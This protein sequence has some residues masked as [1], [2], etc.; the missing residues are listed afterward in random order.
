MSRHTLT[1]RKVVLSRIIITA[2]TLLETLNTNIVYSTEKIYLEVKIH[3]RVFFNKQV[4]NATSS[5]AVKQDLYPDYIF[6]HVVRLQPKSWVGSCA[7]RAEFFGW[8]KGKYINLS[9]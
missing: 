9:I 2:Q 8:Y 6:G 4:F 5:T 1:S 7:L 3:Q